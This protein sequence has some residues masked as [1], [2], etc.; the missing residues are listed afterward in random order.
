MI[1]FENLSNYLVLIF[2]NIDCVF[3]ALF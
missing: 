3:S 1:I 2:W